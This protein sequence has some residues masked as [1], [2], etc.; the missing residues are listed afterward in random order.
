MRPIRLGLA[1]INCTVGDLDGNAGK[2]MDYSRKAA[3][4]G[5]DLL[6]FPELSVSGYPPEDL[7]LKPQF[8]ADCREKLDEIAKFSAEVPP[9]TL[10][11]GGVD[12]Q[13]D[14]YNGAGVMNNGRLTDVYHKIFLPNYGVFDEQRYFKPGSEGL[15][16]NIRGV[17]V[18]VSIC[19]DIWYPEGP[20]HVEAAAGGA[21]LI[22]NLNA[23]P[24][25][26]GK[27]KLRARMLANRAVDNLAMVAYVNMV[28]GQD[29]LVFDGQ[30]F[31]FNQAGERVAMGGQ[32]AEELVVEDLDADLVVEA[33]QRHAQWRVS[34]EEARRHGLTIRR[35]EIADAAAGGAKPAAP[36]GESSE[37]EP[38]QE[39][40]SAL[41]LGVGDYV[42]KNRFSQVLVG[43]SGGI[44]S[45]LTAA[46]AADALGATKVTS[47]FM[48]S[49]YTS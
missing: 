10:V 25:H 27:G 26:I 7:L 4:L 21:E 44:D 24:Y 35:L 33:R 17:P 41:K 28:G 30:S 49:R 5:V 39:A 42:R 45:A 32:F 43:L 2:I 38:V 36:R 48:P 3:D 31:I 8:V 18:G 19:E 13:T 34:Q 23:S 11:V 6:V 22:V 47:V 14:V 40:F 12:G 46:I 16:V 20:S 9:L 37:M 29:E 15:V 1:Q